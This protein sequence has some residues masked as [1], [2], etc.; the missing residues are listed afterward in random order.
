M[1][2]S[3]GF[4]VCLLYLWPSFATG[5][6]EHQ[7]LMTGQIQSGFMYICTGLTTLLATA[8]G[9]RNVNANIHTQAQTYASV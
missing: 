7:K 6:P 5:P 1:Q 2:V 9:A 4:E 3:G 8:N